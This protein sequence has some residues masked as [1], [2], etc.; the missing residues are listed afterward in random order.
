MR[1]Q[2]KMSWAG[3][4]NF[5]EFLEAQMKQR[6]MSARQFAEF[7]GVAHS[8][9]TR[10]IDPRSPTSPG[11]D[12]LL[13]LAK[14]T[15]TNLGALVELAYPDVASQ[16]AL[17]AKTLLLAQRIEHL[18]DKIRTAILTLLLEVG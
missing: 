1:K 2:T 5:S 13:A 7:I 18:P 16:T 12:F 6:D 8:T 17:S 3:K 4:M 11:L 9:I 14:A 15:G 10:A